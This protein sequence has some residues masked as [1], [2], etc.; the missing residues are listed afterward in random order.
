[1]ALKPVRWPLF[2]LKEGG[3]TLAQRGG[4]CPIPGNI[5]GWV[6]WSSELCGLGEGIPVHDT[7]LEQDGFEGSFQPKPV[8]DLFQDSLKRVRWLQKQLGGH[9]SEREEPRSWGASQRG[10]ASDKKLKLGI[11]PQWSCAELP[12]QQLGQAQLMLRIFKGPCPG[13]KHAAPVTR[14]ALSCVPSASQHM[15]NFRNSLAEENN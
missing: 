2:F 15:G 14:V 7:G 9:N 12:A 10:C 3:K 11:T 5:Q 4:G 13:A 6:G 8:C 1:M